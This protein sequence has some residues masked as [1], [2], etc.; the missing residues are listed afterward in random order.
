[1]ENENYFE[2]LRLK[3]KNSGVE[4]IF[5]PRETIS[6]AR[7]SE[8]W[9]LKSMHFF[10][11]SS[12]MT[13]QAMVFIPDPAH[14]WQYDGEHQGWQRLSQRSNVNYG[15]VTDKLKVRDGWVYRNSF[16]NAKKEMHM[17]LVFVAENFQD[18]KVEHENILEPTKIF[19]EARE[20]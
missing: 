17:S 3:L 2:W 11:R 6:I 20:L 7:T 14:D 9:L 18:V 13:A 19:D 16:F 1:M 12:S 4:N 15:D 8:G 10:G 5:K